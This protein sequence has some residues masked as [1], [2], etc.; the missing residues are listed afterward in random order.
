MA[1]YVKFM[2]RMVT[3]CVL[4]DG[5]DDVIGVHEYLKVDYQQVHADL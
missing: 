1:F 5:F 3:V 2:S 4:S